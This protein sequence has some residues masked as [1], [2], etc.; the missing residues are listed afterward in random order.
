M[1]NDDWPDPSAPPRGADGEPDWAAHDHA[2]RVRLERAIKDALREACIRTTGQ[3]GD[4]DR[5][6]HW[7]LAYIANHLAE[8]CYVDADDEPN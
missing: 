5:E 7:A 4:P 1:V 2:V 6:A 3:S 8:G